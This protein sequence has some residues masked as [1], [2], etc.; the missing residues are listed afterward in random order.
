MTAAVATEDEDGVPLYFATRDLGGRNRLTAGELFPHQDKRLVRGY[1]EAYGVADGDRRP[2][3]Q[4]PFVATV[5]LPA[6]LAQQVVAQNLSLE[7][8]RMLLRSRA[9]RRR[10]NKDAA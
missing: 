8:A 5:V 9:E 3:D 6:A 4:L 10:Y 1:A 2:W 7:E